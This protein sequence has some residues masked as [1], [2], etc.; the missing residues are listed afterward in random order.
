MKYVAE[1]GRDR[2]DCEGAIEEHTVKA[3][4]NWDPGKSEYHS[5]LGSA[6]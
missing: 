3:L 1:F 2:A 4:Q 6:P 5:T